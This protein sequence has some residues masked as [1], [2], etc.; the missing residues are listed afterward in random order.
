M[1]EQEFRGWLVTHV[2]EVL[3]RVGVSEGAVVVDFGCGAG[4]F[5]LTAARLVGPGGRVYAV[6]VERDLLATLARRARF[7]GLDHLETLPVEREPGTEHLPTRSAD[8]V[9]LYD[10]LQFIKQPVELLRALKE[11]LKP[12]GVLSVFPM[13]VGGDRFMGWVAEAGGFLLRERDGL[14]Y[15]LVATDTRS[16]QRSGGGSG[17]GRVRAQRGSRVEEE[18]G[19]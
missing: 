7:E 4:Q 9:L 2:E 3:R 15:N 1:D 13:H 5:S 18:G 12:G 6:D 11:V 19:R 17:A 8:V 16:H 10:V 14:L